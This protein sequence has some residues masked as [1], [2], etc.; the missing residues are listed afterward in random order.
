MRLLIMI[1]FVVVTTSEKSLAVKDGSCSWM[2]DIIALIKGRAGQG[3][4]TH[5]ISLALHT[6]HSQ[7]K[8][9]PLLTLLFCL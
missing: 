9:G 5:L 8:V 6:G 4:K 3:Q 7:K 2:E 1:T